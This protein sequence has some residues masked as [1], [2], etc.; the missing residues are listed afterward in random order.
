MSLRDIPLGGVLDER[1]MRINL[2]TGTGYSV[3]QIIDAYRN[4]D[5]KTEDVVLGLVKLVILAGIV[6]FM[7]V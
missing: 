7:I 6:L 4:E 1:H 2:G 3:L 5:I